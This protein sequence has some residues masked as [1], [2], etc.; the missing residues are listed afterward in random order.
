M[1]LAVLALAGGPADAR[2]QTATQQR[3]AALLKARAGQMAEAQA[4]LRALLAAGTDDGLVA[5][6]LTTLLQQDG[7]P[8]AARASPVERLMAEGYA[9]RRAGNPAAAL[10]AYGEAIRLSRGS[11]GVRN[12]AAGVLID[13]GAPWGAATIAGTSRAIEVQQAEAMVRWGEQVRSPEPARRFEG[14]DAALARIDALLASLPAD[15]KE[16]RRR[17][18]LSRLVALRDRQRMKEAAAE[19]DALRADSP[20]SSA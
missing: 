14:T 4:A 13:L 20:R 16:L 5:M 6:D 3:E 19:G 17:L 15:D 8:A 9:Y 2:A 11:Q 10:K 18:R 12:E 1:L 7:K